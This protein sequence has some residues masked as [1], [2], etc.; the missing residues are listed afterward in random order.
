MLSDWSLERFREAAG[1][2]I[3]V[4]GDRSGI[5][6]PPQTPAGSEAAAHPGSVHAAALEEHAQAM[7]DPDERVRVRAQELFEQALANTN[8]PA[9]GTPRPRW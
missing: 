5:Q 3:R 7:V 6:P 9:A 1:I 2:A 8:Q 4:E